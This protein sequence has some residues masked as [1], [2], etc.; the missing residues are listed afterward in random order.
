MNLFVSKS[1]HYQTDAL[2]TSLKKKW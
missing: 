1:Q 2:Y